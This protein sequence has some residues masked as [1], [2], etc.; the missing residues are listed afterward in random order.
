MVLV[1]MQRVLPRGTWGCSGMVPVFVMGSVSSRDV[2]GVWLLT[3]AVCHPS[4]VRS[5]L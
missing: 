3:G 5:E 2:L 4:A 1:S